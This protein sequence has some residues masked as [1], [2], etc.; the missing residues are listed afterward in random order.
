MGRKFQINRVAPIAGKPAL[1]AN[2][3]DS[4]LMHSVSIFLFPTR[5]SS[6][7]IIPAFELLAPLQNQGLVC[8]FR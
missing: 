2:R 4:L 1:T 3:G 7:K 5:A 8:V 6:E